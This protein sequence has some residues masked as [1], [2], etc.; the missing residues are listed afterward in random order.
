MNILSPLLLAMTA[1]TPFCKGSLVDTDTRWDMCSAMMDDRQDFE[2]DPTHPCYIPVSRF[3]AVYSFLGHEG[4]NYNNIPVNYPQFL[5]EHIKETVS[6]HGLQEDELISSYLGSL[7][8]RDTIFSLKCFNEKSLND[9]LAFTSINSTYWSSVRIK[10]SFIG[11]EIIWLV[12]VRPMEAQL[13]PEANSA[14]SLLIYLMV[15]L[16]DFKKLN[17]YLPMNLVLQNF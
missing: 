14:F 4:K 2:K 8:C 17:M 13:M 7:G 1:G 6:G 3:G 5:K 15:R 10:P 12:E 11:N 16:L 9:M